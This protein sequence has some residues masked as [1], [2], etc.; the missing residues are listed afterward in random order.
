MAAAS[1]G[2][3][4]LVTFVLDVSSAMGEPREGRTRLERCMA[5]AS[6]RVL[7]MVGRVGG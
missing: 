2:Q 5:F 6:L 7:E 4:T 3:R 1:L